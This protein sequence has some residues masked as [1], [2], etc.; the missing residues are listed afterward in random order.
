MDGIAAALQGRL[1]GDAEWKFTAQAKPMLRFSVGVTDSYGQQRGDPVQ[2]VRVVLFGD[3]ASE[4]GERGLA[5][6]SEVYCEGRVKINRWQPADGGPERADLELF[7]FVVQP[8]GQIGRPRPAEP[9]RPVAA[10]PNGHPAA[11]TPGPYDR[12]SF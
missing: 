5:K 6:G 2:W 1:G 8:I 10:R 4:L 9:Q 12:G 7:A 3:R 11:T